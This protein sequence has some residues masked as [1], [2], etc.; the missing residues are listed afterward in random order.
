MATGADVSA[1][2]YGVHLDIMK[3]EKRTACIAHLTRA[4]CPG[5]GGWADL[6]PPWLG[7]NVDKDGPTQRQY[8]GGHHVM[9]LEN[10][11]Q[12]CQKVS[13][14]VKLAVIDLLI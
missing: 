14:D 9:G 6:P 3:R 12:A 8:R 7:G 5:A 4:K 2:D 1:V 13:S 11:E 10:H